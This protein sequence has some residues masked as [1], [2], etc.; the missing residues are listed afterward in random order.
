VAELRA[1]GAEERA[2]LRV[3]HVT[4][5]F[6]GVLALGDV[7]L[8]APAG[9]V[10]G[11][12][13]PNGAGKTTL[14]DVVTGIRR[15][16]AGR[17]RLGGRDVTR[18][19]PHGRA[20]LGM[21]R[22]FQRLELF[23]SLTARE[24]VA[25][26][27]GTRRR[28][29]AGGRARPDVAT[30]LAQVGLQAEADTPADL[31]P[32]GQARL[33]ELA[34]ALATGPQVLLLDEPSAG[35]DPDETAALGRVLGALAGEGLAVLLVEHD[36][37]LVMGV[38]RQ[39]VVLDAGTVI[40]VGS[41]AAVQ[42]DPAV[43]AAYLGEAEVAPEPTAPTVRVAAPAPAE[44]PSAVPALELAGIDAG[45]GRIEVL[46]QVDL[47]VPAG[48]VAALLGPNGAG[49]ST[50]IAAAG[51]RLRPTAGQVRLFGDDVTG[52]ASD[53]L[54]RRGLC[55]I[56]E[57]RAVFANLTVAENLRMFGA[58]NAE[59]RAG[60]LEARAYERFPVLK[61]RRRQLA[62]R[63]SGGE[64][65]MLALARA[66]G[67]APRLLLLDE[68]SMGLAPLI[69]QSLYEAVVDMVRRERI[70]VLLVE[71]FA[72]TALAI[73]DEAAVMAQG[74]I[75]LRG[76]PAEVAGGLVHAYLGEEAG[77]PL[78]GGK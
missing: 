16:E 47:S 59:V 63:L 70:A 57:G 52:V 71:Q 37:D 28:H 22:T 60:E 35:L 4:V 75:V 72:R 41:P 24:N 58:R 76:T 11:L 48:S 77:A 31:L 53:V 73:A 33:L 66:L 61:E 12:I 8:E 45:Y 14:F 64:Q 9:A 2:D 67:G 34:R 26:A 18:V 20:R 13:G 43:R 56:P 54:A 30:V 25:L 32:T 39:V 17:V 27:A 3:E 7:S 36:M 68:L 6:G 42:G 49:K 38:C 19:K 55:T 50:L 74:R 15:P 51:G 44:A 40:A 69:V 1:A 78:G 23:G 21:S 29:G 10:T 5:R 46:H 65:Q 62:G